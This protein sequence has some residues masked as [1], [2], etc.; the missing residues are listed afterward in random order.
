VPFCS[1][2]IRKAFGVAGAANT[3]PGS[4][5]FRYAWPSG[6]WGSLPIEGGIEVGYKAELAE[7]DDYDAH[8]ASIK[9]RLN[10]VRSPFRSAE[11]FEIEDIINPQETRQHLCNWIN[12]AYQAL[13]TGTC[14][15]SYRP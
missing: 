9:E 15:F 12:L 13:Q 11:F 4:H 8:L 2:V 5:H 3:K 10:R 7:A 14:H 6:D 1:V